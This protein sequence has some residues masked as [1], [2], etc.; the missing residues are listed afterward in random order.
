[1]QINQDTSHKWGVEKEGR[2]KRLVMK[3]K[4]FNVKK[5]TKRT[6]SCIIVQFGF[7]SQRQTKTMTMMNMTTRAH[8]ATTMPTWM[9]LW[10][11]LSTAAGTK[12]TH[13]RYPIQIWMFKLQVRLHFPYCILK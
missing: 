13:F 5:L 6:K 10:R 4:E 2:A 7:Y 1:M 12:Q 9:S 11:V 3:T 8:K